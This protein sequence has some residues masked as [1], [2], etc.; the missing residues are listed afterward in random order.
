MVMDYNV[1]FFFTRKH[2]KL[3]QKEVISL[4]KLLLCIPLVFSLYG[5]LDDEKEKS[6]DDKVTTTG[7]VEKSTSETIPKEKGMSVE[8]LQTAVNPYLSKYDELYKKIN[9]LCLKAEET[10]TAP[11]EKEITLLQ[12]E[13]HDIWFVQIEKLLPKTRNYDRLVPNL[14]QYF[15]QLESSLLIW[16]DESRD[17]QDKVINCGYG[18]DNASNF[19]QQFTDQYNTLQK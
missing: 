15:S 9:D 13:L 11:T 3:I 19:Y 1:I 10:Q 6:S 18:L 17:L 8:E 5:C 14:Q 2:C 12:N 4:K 7:E 16:S